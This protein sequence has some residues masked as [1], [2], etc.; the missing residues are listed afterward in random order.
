MTYFFTNLV[1][2]LFIYDYAYSYCTPS[3]NT[4]WPSSQEIDHL[5]AMLNGQLLMPTDTNYNISNSK[6]KYITIRPYFVLLPTDKDDIINSISFIRDH[7]LELSIFSTGH[8]T[9]G[10]SEGIY[11]NSFQINFSN[12]KKIQLIEYETDEYAVKV[13]T[14][15]NFGI[16]YSFVDEISFSNTSYDSYLIAGGDCG[17]VGLAGY[18]MGGGEPVL[19]RYLGLGVDSIIEYEIIIANGS[20]LVANNSHNTDLFWALRGG[21]GGTFGV[22][23]NI[24]MKVVNYENGK[25]PQKGVTSVV[26]TYPFYDDENNLIGDQLLTHFWTECMSMGLS[27]NINGHMNIV[28]NPMENAF[29][30]LNLLYMGNL[31]SSLN[32]EGM[33][34]FFDYQSMNQ[35]QNETIYTYYESYQDWHLTIGEDNSFKQYGFDTILSQDNITNNND[36]FISEIVNFANELLFD[37]NFTSQD[38]DGS[39]SLSVMLLGGKA[40]QN[41]ID[42]ALNPCWRTPYGMDVYFAAFWKNTLYDDIITSFL[43]GYSNIFMDY[44]CGAYFNDD[45]ENSLN[46]KRQYWGIQNY[47]KLLN[48][49]NKY[50]PK[51]YLFNCFHCIGDDP[52]P[53]ISTTFIPE[54]T[55]QEIGIT[56]VSDKSYIWITILVISLVLIFV[57]AIGFLIYRRRKRNDRFAPYEF[58][59]LSDQGSGAIN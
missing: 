5:K 34:C 7:N 52:T 8:S 54:T 24:T 6:N 40:A 43:D 30:E 58:A 19:L 42:V 3:N 45:I 36:Q 15:A 9:S 25:S 44:G 56:N 51:P 32:D 26:A 38:I 46:W 49:K 33:K 41:S 55:S 29:I 28:I 59:M 48:I 35:L 2:L 14:G 10:R 50:D 47:N 11:N 21:G 31:N 13:E 27:N 1:S 53:I 17:T 16:I 12:N 4:C 37:V 20:I 22:V 23:T 57:L 39:I 18:S